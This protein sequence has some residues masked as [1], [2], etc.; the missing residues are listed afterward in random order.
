MSIQPTPSVE[1]FVATTC[2]DVDTDKVVCEYECGDTYLRRAV[3]SDD[4]CKWLIENGHAEDVNDDGE[5]VFYWSSEDGEDGGYTHQDLS[6][7]FMSE[8]EET[9]NAYAKTLPEWEV[10]KALVTA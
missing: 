7:W 6:D 10:F 3:D 2:Y 4:Y 1:E 5:L 9:T 8:G